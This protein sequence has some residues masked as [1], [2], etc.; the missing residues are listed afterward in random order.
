[1]FAN[2][3]NRFKMALPIIEHPEQDNAKLKQKNVSLC[4]LLDTRIKNRDNTF[5]IRIRIIHERK[6]K[7][8]TTKIKATKEQYIKIVNGNPRGTLRE[9]KVVI[10]ELLKKANDTILNMGS[11]SFELFKKKFFGKPGRLSNVHEAFI[12]HIKQLK[13]KG[14]INTA[15]TYITASKQLKKYHSKELKFDEI[16]PSFLIGWEN[17][18]KQDGKSPTTISINTRCVRKLYNDAIKR[19]D[20]KQEL[21]P[22]GNED[23]DLYQPPEAR[24]IKKALSKQDLKKIF[25]YQ[26]EEGSPEQFSRDMFIFSYLG[27]GMNFNDISRLKYSNI[28][29]GEIVFIRQKTASRR[30]IKP[31]AVPIDEDM[32]RIIDTYGT[33]PVM[34][35]NY[36]FSVLIAGLTPAQE[37]A[38]IKQATKQTNKYLKRIAIKIGIDNNIST[39]YARHSFASVLK[40][41][42]E[43]IAYIS[44]SL[45]HADLKTTENYLSSFDSEKRKESQK[46]LK[47]F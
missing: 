13:A 1:M 32:Q 36:I 5:T 40:L 22:F 29:N 15:G 2:I 33:K 16:T 31:I 28:H 37:T 3:Q 6:A 38:R 42:G 8:Y 45:G 17:F 27:N 10:Y 14:Q 11:F 46:K 24:N 18:M 25:E 35:D 44:E 41:S 7:Y 23:E 39:Y 20:A 19:G 21:Y 30:K 47:A 4:A 34:P 9:N 26:A 12:E 43:N